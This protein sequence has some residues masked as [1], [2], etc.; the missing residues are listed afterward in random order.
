MM[1]TKS[2]DKCNT[3]N[4]LKCLNSL[5]KEAHIKMICINLEIIKLRDYVKMNKL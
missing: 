2:S 4:S 3:N 1:C 5:K